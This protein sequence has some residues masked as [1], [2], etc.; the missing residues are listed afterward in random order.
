M[1]TRLIIKDRVYIP[2]RKVDLDKLEN[3]FV[4][5]VYNEDKCNSCDFRSERHTDVCDNCMSYGGTFKLYNEREIDGREYYGIPV[6]Y[7]SKVEKIVTDSEI[8]VKSDTRSK[9]RFKYSIEF[10]A[11]PYDYQVEAVKEMCKHDNGFLESPPRTGK[12]VMGTMIICKLG[13]K[14]LIIASQRD[15]L[16]GFYDT[17]CGNVKEGVTAFTNAHDIEKFEGVKIVGFCKTFEEFKK[18]DICLATYQ[19]FLSSGGKQLLQKV[20]RMFGIVLLDE[21]HDCGALELSK[22]LNQFESKYRYALSGTPDRKDG[23][24]FIAHSIVGPVR[25][26]SKVETLVPSV[27]FIE[28]GFNSTQNYTVLSYAYKALERNRTRTRLI[29]NTAVTMLREGRSIVIPVV[30]V[31]FMKTLVKKI[32]KAY[33][34]TIAAGFHGGLKKTKTYDE[35]RDL[36]RRA[37]SGKIRCVVGIRKIVQVGIN[38]PRWDTLFM[39]CPIS[40]APK[41][42]QETSRILTPVEGKPTPTIVMFLDNMSFARGCLRSCLY[43]Q[44]FY[45]MGF[46]INSVE[47]KRVARYVSHAKFT[48]SSDSYSEIK[49]RRFL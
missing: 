16:Q 46:K 43:K 9:V 26:R 18:Y 36:I 44:G 15:W 30:H 31:D 20:K 14:T 27:K 11:K 41:L 7:R 3:I 21:G 12:T 28:T 17:I 8:V 29:V 25:Y 32:N 47:A 6:G 42:K 40:N 4:R 10:T 37:R 33:G 2:E 35:R 5:A 49:T 38:V 39:V 34:S 22:I 19:T 1:A 48:A 45:S 13:L 24:I 23:K